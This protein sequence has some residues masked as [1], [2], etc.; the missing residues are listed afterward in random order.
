[1]TAARFSGAV[2][3]LDG[4]I[5]NSMPLLLDALAAVLGKRGVSVD[6]EFCLRW[7]GQRLSME[8]LLQHH[9]VGHVDVTGFRSEFGADFTE[10]VG[11]SVDWKDGAEALLSKFAAAGVPMAVLTNA[12][13]RHLDIANGRLGIGRYCKVLLTPADVGYRHK[14]MPDGLLFAV[15][16]L[17]VPIEECIYVG[18]QHFDLLTARNAGMTSVFVRTEHSGPT[19]IEPDFEFG[20]ISE[21][22]TL[23]NPLIPA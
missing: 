22:S 13:P 9:G 1:M 16:R 10:R 18:D 3:D 19:D 11:N 12:P 8:A 5:I 17:G 15:Q 23:F 14:P 21:V 6:R 7:H 4:T 20:C 2:F